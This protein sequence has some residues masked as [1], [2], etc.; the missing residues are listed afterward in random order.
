MEKEKEIKCSLHLGEWIQ[1]MWLYMHNE[2]L[3][4]NS[5]ICDNK[6]ESRGNYAKQVSQT[7]KD[8]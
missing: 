5:D 8:E 2:M 7:Q 3:S 4:R 6:D 1:K